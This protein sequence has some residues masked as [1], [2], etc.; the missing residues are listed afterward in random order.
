MFDKFE[1]EDEAL[2]NAEGY[3]TKEAPEDELYENLWEDYQSL[4]ASLVI[5][6]ESGGKKNA[7]ERLFIEQDIFAHS[8]NDL[9]QTDVMTHDIDTGTAPS[10][11]QAPYRAALSIHAFIKKEV[12]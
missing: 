10:I 5:P 9:G 11:K 2:D 8:T 1:Y 3:Y 12:A 6:P 4:A 7:H